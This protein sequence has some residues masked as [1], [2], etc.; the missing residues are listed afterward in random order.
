MSAL[1]TMTRKS[2]PR[3]PRSK[4][5]AQASALREARQ[6]PRRRG[7][8]PV[9]GQIRLPSPGSILLQVSRPL[10]PRARGKGAKKASYEMSERRGCSEKSAKRR[11]LNPIRSFFLR[12]ERLAPAESRGPR[13]LQGG[14]CDRGRRS[15]LLRTARIAAYSTRGGRGVG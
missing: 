5:H 12:R 1:C 13:E 2:T 10:F 3:K 7:R 8:G 15:R 6:A 9:R 14:A 4:G 11:I